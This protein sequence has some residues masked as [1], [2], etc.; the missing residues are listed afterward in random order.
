MKSKIYLEE[1]VENKD[2]R[3]GQALQYF[4]CIIVDL[5]GVEHKALFTTDRI[6]KATKRGDENRED[7]DEE[8]SK[9][10]FGIFG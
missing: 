8:R 10:L 7:F 4:P 3:F 6:E 1:V 5:N 9:F 2:R